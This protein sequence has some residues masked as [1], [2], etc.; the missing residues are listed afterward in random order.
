MNAT[1]MVQESKY[2]EAVSPF[3]VQKPGKTRVNRLNNQETRVDNATRVSMPAE[4][5]RSW[6][7]ALERK[8]LPHQNT[9]ADARIRSKKP[10]PLKDTAS[11]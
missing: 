8:C 9:E 5:W 6:V 7:K 2:R 4:K 3:D 11:S 1:I 10:F